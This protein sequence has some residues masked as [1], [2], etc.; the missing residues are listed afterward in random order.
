[1]LAD[2]R[3]RLNAR[4]GLAVPDWRTGGAGPLIGKFE[5]VTADYLEG[6]VQDLSAPECPVQVEIVAD[7]AVVAAVLA[8]RHRDDLL[9]AGLGSGRH[10][11]R[12]PM[13]RPGARIDVRRAT[14]YAVVPG[15]PIWCS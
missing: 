13:R 4:A 8:N 1:M 6:W 15:S 9:A 2:I 12:V 11:F 7:G 3:Q 10:A 5:R 14:D